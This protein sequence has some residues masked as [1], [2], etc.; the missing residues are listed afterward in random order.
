MLVMMR[1]VVLL[2]TYAIGQGGR[3]FSSWMVGRTPLGLVAWR[4]SQEVVK[5][6]L[7][8]VSVFGLRT[9]EAGR[10]QQWRGQKGMKL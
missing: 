1:V 8:R 3:I 6:L 10:C 4:G 2:S 5:V 7:R 9:R